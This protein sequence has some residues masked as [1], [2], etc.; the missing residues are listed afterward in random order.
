MT[1][2]PQFVEKEDFL[3]FVKKFVELE[4]EKDGTNIIVFHKKLWYYFSFNYT[5]DE[6]RDKELTDKAKRCTVFIMN[7]LR[8]G[9]GE[10]KAAT[11]NDN[12]VWKTINAD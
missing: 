10:L 4:Y 5:G 3:S 8:V 2:N 7:D 12:G 11:Y 1:I 6:Q 9:T